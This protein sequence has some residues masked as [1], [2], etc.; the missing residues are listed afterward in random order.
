MESPSDLARAREI[1]AVD[2]AVAVSWIRDR[3]IP[4]ENLRASAGT[5]FRVWTLIERPSELPAALGALEH[6]ADGVV[7]PADSFEAVDAIQGAL[8]NRPPVLTGWRLARLRTVRPAGMGDRVL[9]DT[10]SI[11]RP[12]EGLLVGSTAAFLFHVASEVGGIGLY[13]ATV[14]PGQRR[15]GPLLRPAGGR[16]DTIPFRVGTRGCG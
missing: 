3:I 10:T 5:S 16:I 15:R 12:T 6:G 7:I 14:L 2:G 1:G 8:E 11:L 4:L 9:V 13:P